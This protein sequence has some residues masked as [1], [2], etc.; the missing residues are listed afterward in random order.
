M[1]P[2]WRSTSA[3][4]CPALLADRPGALARVTRALADADINIE[5]LFILG[6]H[7]DGLEVAIA[8]DDPEAAEPMLP[9]RGSLTE[10]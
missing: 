9:I 7:S 4:S 2:A 5:A 8:V 10:V 1:M 6:S 3:Q